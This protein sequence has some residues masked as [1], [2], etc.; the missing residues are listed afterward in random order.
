MKAIHFVWLFFLIVIIVFLSMILYRTCTY[1]Q[2]PQ[3]QAFSLIPDNVSLIVKGKYAENILEFDKENAYF[4]SFLSSEKQRKRM[5]CLFSML[6]YKQLAQNA[7]LYLSLHN[8]PNDEWTIILETSKSY[9][10]VLLD[11][12]D[13]LRLRFYKETF[14][15]K[16]NTIYVFSIN[17]ENVYLNHHNG[18]LLMT[19]SEN[20]MRQAVNKLEIHKNT[21]QLAVNAIPVQRDENAEI[22]VFVQYNYFIP[23]LKNKI[24]QMEG[25][26]AA[27]DI[28][29]T[30]QWSVFELNTKKQAV[31]LS[32]YT[33]VDTAN[34]LSKLLIHRNNNLDILKMLPYNANRIFSIKANCAQDWKKMKPM[35]QP[36]EDFFSLTSP[37]QIVTFDIENDTTVFHYL[38]IKSENSSEA[39]FHLYNSLLSSFEKNHAV[40][41][42]FHIGSQLVGHINLSNFVF[43]KLGI[44][45]Q[46]PHLKYYTVI[47]D[48]LIFTDKKEGMLACVE[49]LRYNNTLNKSA[50]YQSSQ[51]YFTN[52]ANMFYYGCFANRL[53]RMQ[54]YAKSDAILLMDMLLK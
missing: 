8:N 23:Y 1:F 9:N 37:N 12:I 51:N 38:L 20:L 15:Y 48:Y 40:L 6:N 14:V 16:N 36:Q 45:N 49:Q 52:E 4:L 21:I 13:S 28:L 33:I 3:F 44:C 27:L 47:D 34:H 31:L 46:L 22:H 54:L 5:N 50:D 24:Q 17:N 42:T 32:G 30:C 29:K 19:Y 7:S 25:N 39:S 26:T 2:K 35:V 10:A 53:I 43:A 11:F 41:D 18:V